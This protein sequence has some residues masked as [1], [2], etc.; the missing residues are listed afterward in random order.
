MAI[1][2]KWQQSKLELKKYNSFYLCSVQCNLAKWNSFIVAR[3]HSH[4][5]YIKLI[6]RECRHHKIFPFLSHLVTFEMMENFVWHSIWNLVGE[7]CFHIPPPAAHFRLTHPLACLLVPAPSHSRMHFY[8]H[9]CCLS[10]FI[11]CLKPGSIQWWRCPLIFIAT[12]CRKNET[13]NW[14][15]RRKYSSTC[16]RWKSKKDHVQVEH[17][18]RKKERMAASI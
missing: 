17:Q 15:E 5:T 6:H 14:N 18:K 12:L 8:R 7:R 4:I 3:T 1:K 9:C 11:H 10:S 2:L 16:K 13:K